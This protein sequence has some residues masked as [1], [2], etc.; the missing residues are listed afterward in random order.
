MSYRLDEGKAR[1]LDPL[2]ADDN[3]S[4][5]I[6]ILVPLVILDVSGE[7]L[8]IYLGQSASLLSLL[9]SVHR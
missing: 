4:E 3:D 6:A 5:S 2:K 9:V 1:Y 8:S 7:R